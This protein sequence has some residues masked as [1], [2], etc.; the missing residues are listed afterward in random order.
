MLID[1]TVEVV[2]GQSYDGIL[3]KNKNL[4]ISC[5][6]HCFVISHARRAIIQVLKSLR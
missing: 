4:E 1:R 3:T 5:F 2:G 6:S